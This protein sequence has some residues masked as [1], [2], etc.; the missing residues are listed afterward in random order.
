MTA[1][2]I[3]A[4]QPASVR[5]RVSV[6]PMDCLREQNFGNSE[7]L[8]YSEWRTSDARQADVETP[9][10]MAARADRF[11]ESCIVQ[12]LE[13]P[14]S[15]TVVVV[16]HGKMLQ[17]LWSQILAWTN[18][19][20]VLCDREL[21]VNSNSIDYTRIGAWSNTGFLHVTFTPSDRPSTIHTP[22]LESPLITHRACNGGEP[23]ATTSHEADS[24]LARRSWSASILAINGRPHLH[25]FRRTRGGVGSSQH[26]ERQ[27]T[28]DRFF[29]RSR[30]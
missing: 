29:A 2:Q 30:T 27:S 15:P 9:A 22:A 21:L 12:L 16:S 14:V 26:D 6:I 18:P 1:E 10:A 28:L 5:Q 17:V 3:L 23:H 20:T 25:G 7:G 19:T 13:A 4:A 24:S 11:I 8:H